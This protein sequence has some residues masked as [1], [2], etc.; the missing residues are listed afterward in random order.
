[1]LQRTRASQ[2]EEFLPDFAKRF[3]TPNDLVKGGEE[4]VA[5]V[6]RRLGLHWRGAHLYE[7]A[8]ALSASGARPPST[9]SELR[10]IRGIGP[11]T[12][13]A[14]LSLHRNKRAVIVDSNVARWLS[15]LTGRPY[16]K[17][18][19]HVG[20]VNKLAALLTPSR[21]FREFNYAVLDFSMTVCTVREPSCADCPF[22]RDCVF[23]I[24][25]LVIGSDIA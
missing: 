22:R 2:V 7:I 3:P 17:D 1:M 18:P 24:Q 5:E 11:Y 20:W 13:A 19:R 6:T 21:N 23:G 8:Q 10:A 12:A 4:A 25:R 9:N 15:R 16:P 14:W